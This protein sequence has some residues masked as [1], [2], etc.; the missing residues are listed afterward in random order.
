MFFIKSKR[1]LGRSRRSEGL[2]Y[3]HAPASAGVVKT[4][5]RGTC[6]LWP[7]YLL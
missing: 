4:Y 3:L 6:C 2:I 7:D 1:P 5:A